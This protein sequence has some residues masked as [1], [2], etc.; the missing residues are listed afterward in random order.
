MITVKLS[1]N[2]EKKIRILKMI[3]VFV[4]VAI[5]CYG[6]PVFAAECGGANTALIDCE[7]TEGGVWHIL[8]L[9]LDLLSM[10]IGILGVIGISVAGV[11]FLTSKGNPEQAGKAKTRIFQL[12]IGLAMYALLF[13]GLEW[14]LPGGIIESQSNLADIGSSKTVAEQ[15]A[16]R[17]ADYAKRKAERE[18]EKQAK[19]DVASS[20]EE[21]LEDLT[22]K[23]IRQLLNKTA[24]RFATNRKAYKKAV[25][26]VEIGKTKGDGA[27]N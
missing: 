19:V 27:D 15:E 20:S 8:S 5:I 21:S 26:A 25:K 16:K 2:Y 22:N 24:K 10:G 9:I 1:S 6:T 3:L 23:E 7:E 12:V 4:M 11:Q 17:Q 14:L 13:V 18:A